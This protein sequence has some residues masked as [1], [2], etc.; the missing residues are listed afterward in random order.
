MLVITSGSALIG[1]V[2]AGPERQP[3]LRSL[4]SVRA[5]QILDNPY[6]YT[7]YKSDVTHGV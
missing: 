6:T 5:F 2:V 4:V 1:V 7:K 3:R